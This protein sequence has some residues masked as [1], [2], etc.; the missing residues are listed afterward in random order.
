MLKNLSSDLI[1]FGG[2]NAVK[3][4]I[5]ILMLPILTAQ[6]TVDEFGTLALIDS[7]I[8]FLVPL[9]M[10]G[11]SSSASV[12]YHKLDAENYSSYVCNALFIAFISFFCFSI[13]SLIFKNQ[14]NQFFGFQGYIVC[15][16][17]VLCNSAG[18]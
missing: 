5:P 18:L 7:V 13:L 3:S 6:L 1:V 8:L 4:L 12:F 17:S 9:V 14:L 15:F 10:I 11:I 16:F 2:L